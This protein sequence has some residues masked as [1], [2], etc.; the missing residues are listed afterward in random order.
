[1][2]SAFHGLLSTYCAQ[3]AKRC[4]GTVGLEKVAEMNQLII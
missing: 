1:M 2:Q 3:G 4:V